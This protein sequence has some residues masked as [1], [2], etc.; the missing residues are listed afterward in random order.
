MLILLT[1]PIG[2]GKS[3]AEHILCEILQQKSESFAD[4]LKKI[5]LIFGFEHHEVYGTQQ[6]KLVPNKIWG[7]TGRTFCQQFGTEICRNTLPDVIPEMKNVWI[8]LMEEKIKVNRNIII[9]DG[10]FEDEVELVRKYHGLVLKMNRPN[11]TKNIDESKHTSESQ[12]LDFDFEIDNVGTIEDL[13]MQLTNF[14]KFIKQ[15]GTLDEYGCNLRG[16]R[17]RE[18]N[19]SNTSDS[20]GPVLENYMDVQRER[21]KLQYDI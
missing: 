10:R 15:S 19:D 8:Q 3:E 11:R 4:P 20:I 5:A 12:Y 6:Q 2:S 21:A 1:G 14:I 9:S 16:K 18:K 17:I 7:V 13:R